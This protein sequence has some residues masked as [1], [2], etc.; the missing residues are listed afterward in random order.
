[1]WVALKTVNAKKYFF[2]VLQMSMSVKGGGMRK[3][4][5]SPPWRHCAKPLAVSAR[6]TWLHAECCKGK[7][8]IGKGKG[9]CVDLKSA[10]KSKQKNIIIFFFVL[11]V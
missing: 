6:C 11:N 3:G 7:I 4:A 2:T 1:M 5:S 8:A 9:E 10:H